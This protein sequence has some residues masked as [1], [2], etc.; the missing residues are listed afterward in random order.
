MKAV[1]AA[2]PGKGSKRVGGFVSSRPGGES[3]AL[4]VDG[5]SGTGSNNTAPEIYAHELGHVV[6]VGGRYSDDPEWISAHETDVLRNAAGHILST[7][8]W[9]SPAES[10][11]EFHRVLWDTGPE[12]AKIKF[13]NCAAFYAERDLL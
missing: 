5:G 7:Y 11:A 12:S 1:T 3:A 9:E 2:C 8:A 4:N 13:P 6:N 10:F